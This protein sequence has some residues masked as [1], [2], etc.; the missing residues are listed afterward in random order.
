MMLS[1]ILNRWFVG[2]IPVIPETPGKLAV[3]WLMLSL[4]AAPITA[5]CVW[6][7]PPK[8]EKIIIF[9]GGFIPA[10]VMQAIVFFVV[11]KHAG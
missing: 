6:L 11:A 3:S 5:L 1:V 4:I 8:A 9:F 2:G 7:A 10:I